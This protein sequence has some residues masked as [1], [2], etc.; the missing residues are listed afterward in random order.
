MTEGQRL[1]GAGGGQLRNVPGQ[2]NP[3]A[4]ADGRG[5]Q[6]HALKVNA[7]LL[8]LNTTAPRKCTCTCIPSFV[9]DRTTVP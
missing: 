9:G 3:A 1:G 7:T 6:D 8:K 2:G 4:D 5:P